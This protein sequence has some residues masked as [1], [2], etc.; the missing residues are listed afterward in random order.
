M[1]QVSAEVEQFFSEY[2]RYANEGDAAGTASQFTEFFMAADPAGARAVPAKALLAAV[3]QRRKLTEEAGN[4]RTKLLSVEEKE[5][6]DRYVLVETE[7]LME[8]GPDKPV[9]GI[10]LRSTFIVYRSEGGLK[11]VFYLAHQ[12]LMEVLMESGVLPSRAHG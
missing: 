7:W 9:K 2:E 8:F 11:I 12:N 4:H 1:R 10:G 3:P 5:L 6:G